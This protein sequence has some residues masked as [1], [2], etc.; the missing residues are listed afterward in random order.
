MHSQIKTE[1]ASAAATTTTHL[2]I[3]YLRAA[4]R[5]NIQSLTYSQPAFTAII[6]YL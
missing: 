2:T 3:L 4:T 6:Q 1:A 5:K